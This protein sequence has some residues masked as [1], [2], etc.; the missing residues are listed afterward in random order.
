M[1]NTLKATVQGGKIEWRD[2]TEDIVPR[3][4]PIDVLVTILE[5]HPDAPSPEERGRRRVAALQKLAALNA[6]STIDNPAHWQQETRKD[7]D[8]P[9]RPS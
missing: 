3:D 8:L 7:R 9:G 6:F 1:Q 4:R 5:D 2:V